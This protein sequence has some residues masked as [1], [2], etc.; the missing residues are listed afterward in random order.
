MILKIYCEKVIPILILKILTI[1]CFVMS[2]AL[3]LPLISKQSETVDNN[4]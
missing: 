1:F 4:V 2:E 3:A